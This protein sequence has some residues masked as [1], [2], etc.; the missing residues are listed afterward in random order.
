MGTSQACTKAPS[1]HAVQLPDAQVCNADL[2][3][4]SDFL[5]EDFFNAA[6]EPPSMKQKGAAVKGRAGFR[7]YTYAVDG[8]SA[9]LANAEEELDWD[10]SHRSHISDLDRAEEFQ[11]KKLEVIRQAKEAA[12]AFEMTEEARRRDAAAT[13]AQE[14]RLGDKKTPSQVS[15]TL[16]SEYN[17]LGI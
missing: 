8:S 15:T 12:L 3:A 16:A 13:K 14:G 2:P 6:E 9:N 7:E 5:E 17:S 4:C 10:L 1:C 11:N